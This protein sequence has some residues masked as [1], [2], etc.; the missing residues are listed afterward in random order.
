MGPW[1]LAQNIIGGLWRVQD[2]TETIRLGLIGGGM[3]H[4]EAARL[5]RHYVKEGYLIDYF[6]C[7]YE[8]L[9]AALQGVEDEEEEPDEDPTVTSG[10]SGS[11]L[12]VNSTV[13]E[14]QQDSPLNK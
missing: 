3:R 9:L 14:H 11:S 1:L 12:G 10:S 5:I 13:M 6:M 8:V 2:V 4:E 7:A